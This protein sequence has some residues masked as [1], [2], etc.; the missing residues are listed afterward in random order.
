MTMSDREGL[1]ARIRL[2]RRPVAAPDRANE[3]PNE[4]PGTDPDDPQPERIRLLEARVAHL[5]SLL[6][7]FQDSVHRESKRHSELIAELQNQVEPGAMSAVLAEDARNR[8]L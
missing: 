8:G 2:M 7:G 4:R 3:R 6:Q 1:I 5:E